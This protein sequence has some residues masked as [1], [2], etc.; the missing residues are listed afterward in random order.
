MFFFGNKQLGDVY[1][2]LQQ[3]EFGSSLSSLPGVDGGVYGL[4]WSAAVAVVAT[5][6]EAG[7]LESTSILRMQAPR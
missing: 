2:G 4:Y 1:H 6:P 5:G 3:T 7:R